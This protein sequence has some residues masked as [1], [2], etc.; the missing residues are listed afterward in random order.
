MEQIASAS[1][2]MLE[3]EEAIPEEWGNVFRLSILILH[4]ANKG[5]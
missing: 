5:K 1:A 4:P 3:A 2:D